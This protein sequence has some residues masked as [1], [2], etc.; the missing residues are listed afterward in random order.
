MSKSFG[1]AGLR[2][3][4]VITNSDRIA[5]LRKI[6]APYP[7]PKTTENTILKLLDDENL[8]N[9]ASQITEVKS[10]ENIYIKD[11]HK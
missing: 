3:G 4:T 5:W 11:Y 2:L 9:I 1:M 8:V 7:I 6:L 10:K